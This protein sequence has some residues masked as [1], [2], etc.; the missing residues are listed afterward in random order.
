MRELKQE[1]YTQLRFAQKMVEC[2]SSMECKYCFCL[3]ETDKFY[4][5][6][7]DDHSSQINGLSPM[8]FQKEKNLQKSI[9]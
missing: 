9:A 2:A 3:H 1:E 5:H 6:L 4:K 7:L 8:V